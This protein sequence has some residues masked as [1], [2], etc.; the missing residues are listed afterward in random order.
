MKNKKISNIIM[1][2]LLLAGVVLSS[3]G[4]MGDDIKGNKKPQTVYKQ[5][6]ELG[7]GKQGDA[8]RMNINNINLPFNRKGN[9]ANVNIFD[10]TINDNRSGG[11]FAGRVFLFSAGFFLTGN[12]NGQLFANAV[13]PSTLVEDYV[14]GT[15]ATGQGNPNAVIYVL[16]STDEPFSQSWQDWVDAV[17]LGADFYDGDGDG[18][19]NPVDKNGNGA[20]DPDEDA[21]DLIG[22]ETA[23][24]VF[25]DGLPSSQRRWTSVS[26]LGIEVRQTI[27]AFA[28]AGAIGN[29]IFVRY[30]FT[31]IG[32]ADIY[33]DPD[34]LTD[35]IFGV[36]ADPDLG[37]YDDDRVGVD[38]PRNAGYTYNGEENDDQYGTRPPCYMIDF[39]SGPASFIPG[40]TFIDNDGDGIYTDGVDTPLDTAYSVRG[41]LLGVKAIPGAKNLPISSFVE[42]LNGDP[43]LNDPANK[44]EARNYTLGRDRV[45]DIVDPCTFSHGEVLGGV[46][47][48]TIDPLFWF[49][50]DPVDGTGWVSVDVQDVRQMSNT[51]PFTLKRGVEKEI[52]VAYV[53]GQGTDWL[54]SITVARKIDD[55]AQNIFDLNFLAP[56]PPPPVKPELSSSDN[57]I[58]IVWNTSDQVSY[59]NQT[60]TWDLRFHIFN[61]YAFR[62]NNTADVVQGEQNIVLI[63]SYQV[64]NFI[65]NLYK[66]N[67]ET[68]GIEM[69]YPEAPA[70]N[71][72]NTEVY[73]DPETGRIRLRIYN[74]P[75][76]P[77][78]PITKGKP[79]YFAVVGSAIN[80]DALI[81]KSD[82]TQ[83]VG[84]QGDYYLTVE[85]FAQ[86]AEN[87]K[88][89]VSIVAGSDLYNPPIDVQ[90]ANKIAGPSLGRVG[91]DIIDNAALKNATYEVTFFKDSSSA[92]Y[93]MFWK[94]ED[95]TNNT[96][97]IDTSDKYTYGLSEVSQKVTD[98][99]ITRVEEQIP[100]I[101]EPTYEPAEAVWYAPFDSASN[102]G[103]IY[104][105]KDI[106]Q[107]RVLT[108]FEGK[109]S[110]IITADRLRKVEI[111]FGDQGKAYRY[112]N[113]YVGV[114]PPLRKK[115]Y[116]YAAGVTSDNP[117][118][119]VDLSGVGK[120]GEG[121]VDVP[122]TAWVVDERYGE[123]MQLA[124]GF[125]ESAPDVA[126]F[127]N[128][129]PDGQWDPG[130]SL[131]ASGEVIIIFDAPYDPSGGQIEYT[132]GVFGDTLAWADLMKSALAKE[133]PVSAPATDEQREIFNSP[134][135]NAMYV[136]GLQRKD[137]TSFFTPGDKLTIP[138]DVYPYT[139]ADV[140]QFTLTG[141]TITEDDERA[142]FEKV[143]VY[144]N[145]LYGYNTLTGYDGTPPDEP[146]VTFTNLPTDITVK[147]YSLSGQL[148]RTLTTDDKSEPTSPFLRWDLLNENGLRV[149]S[150]LYLAVVSSPK[151]GDKVLKFTII[152]PQKQI[153]R[154]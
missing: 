145:P 142:L 4:F 27:F 115:T 103:A 33:G 36:W 116:L 3:Y 109:Q 128:G 38:V 66:E 53:V 121:F 85:A 42:Y 18:V 138:I 23:W 7:S 89:I 104:V 63:A 34:E 46:D 112:L 51:G 62:T 101:G 119:T 127:P 83:P 141:T 25:Y 110:D 84:T 114:A 131:N 111:R 93:K 32:G 120:L 22:D 117:D 26:Q 148:L 67:S 113:G 99:F 8:Y 134:W 58:D 153:P 118:V 92:Q 151:F 47:C 59:I 94:L 136:V 9:I 106:P 65:E 126:P 80:Y 78:K 20:W 52:V 132:G 16:K 86:E 149:A 100:T 90:P 123:E 144:P 75:F 102:T 124:V 15:V 61:V 29:L 21:P 107:S 81:F 146:F 143:N 56:S 57:F 24:C 2:F 137:S 154:F 87:P 95:I 73:S 150:G 37:Q 5:T 71:K 28:S 6:S 77:T 108:E 14:P 45:G 49:S 30:R 69:L 10:P 97:L 105:G 152:M 135:F 129:N 133:L 79:Y 98:G 122:F 35:V 43:N 40:E 91:Y 50:G 68:G 55:G 96:V 31:Y 13:A 74:D 39:F 88:K 72:L 41:Q 11:I 82:P 130:D 76:S 147:I 54:N 12:A 139:E 1:V 70:D 64:D 17:N 140:Y 19:Y 48:T 44:E 125:I 60:P